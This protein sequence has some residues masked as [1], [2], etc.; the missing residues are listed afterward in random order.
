MG[1]DP[2]KLSP[3]FK[4]C[5]H[6]PPS[7]S[8]KRAVIAGPLKLAPTFGTVTITEKVSKIGKMNKTETRCKAML[9]TLSAAGFSTGHGGIAFT[10]VRFEAITLYLGDR[11]RYTPDFY[12]EGQLKP[13]FV[14]SKG[15][16]IYPRALNKFKAAVVLFPSFS[17]YLAQWE[18]KS[19]KLTKYS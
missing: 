19:W 11:M 15:S 4:A 2:S 18:N 13:V 3:G 6:E 17:F 16:Y 10:S 5:M 14:E 7:T 8:L 1:L 12:C 9:E